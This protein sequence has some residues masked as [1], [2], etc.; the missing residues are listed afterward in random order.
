MKRTTQRVGSLEHVCDT[1]HGSTFL[2]NEMVKPNELQNVRIITA[3]LSTELQMLQLIDYSPN[4][5]KHVLW[6]NQR[7]LNL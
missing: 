4:Q 7:F 5:S 6:K 1:I 3:V 2:H